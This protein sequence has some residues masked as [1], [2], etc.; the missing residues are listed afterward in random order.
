MVKL[1]LLL[2]SDVAFEAGN[3]PGQSNG[4]YFQSPGFE[5]ALVIR[6]I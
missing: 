6:P 1:Y 3:V 4:A 2:P 5:L